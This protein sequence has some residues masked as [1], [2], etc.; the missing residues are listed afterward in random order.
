M[1]ILTILWMGRYIWIPFPSNEAAYITASR[2]FIKP[3]TII[4]F[5]T[6]FSTKSIHTIGRDDDI[7]VK[8]YPGQSIPEM[9]SNSIIYLTPEELNEH[10][11]FI[12]RINMVQKHKTQKG[13]PL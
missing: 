3:L 12:D 9:D 11:M 1:A 5:I 10:F 2:L 8:L 7:E 6:D 4:Q 13:Q